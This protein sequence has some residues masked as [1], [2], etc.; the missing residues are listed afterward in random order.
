M[1]RRES[2]VGI[3]VALLVATA[4]VLLAAVTE[5]VPPTVR[6]PT[7]L[8]FVVFVPGA[9][10]A[11]ALRVSDLLSF[12]VVSIGVS[13][14]LLLV[15]SEFSLLAGGLSP[16]LVLTGLVVFTVACVTAR[17]VGLRKAG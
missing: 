13:L 3:G 14:A 17:V 4:S 2:V 6:L 15:L 12:S 11:L 16:R 10:F 8:V 7:V 9:A 5:L 1:N